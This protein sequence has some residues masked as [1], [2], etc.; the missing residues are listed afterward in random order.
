MRGG[1]YMVW[2]LAPVAHGGFAP[3]RADHQAGAGPIMAK[4]RPSPRDQQRPRGLGANFA[5]CRPSVAP[6]LTLDPHRPAVWVRISLSVDP[7]PF[8]TLDPR[9]GGRDKSLGR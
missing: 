9:P 5:K 2:G 1:T 6:S 8:L 3:A 4:C 7:P